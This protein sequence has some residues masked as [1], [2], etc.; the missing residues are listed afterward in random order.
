MAFP[1]TGYGFCIKAFC[2][3][4]RRLNPGRLPSI[5]TRG[6]Y[7]SPLWWP[8]ATGANTFRRRWTVS[9]DRPL[10][11]PRFLPS[12][13]RRA[14]ERWTSSRHRKTRILTQ[15]QAGL[16][17]A[18]NQGVEAALGDLIAFFDHD[19]LWH[20]RKLEAQACVLALFA[21]PATCI[22]NFRTVQDADAADPTKVVVPKHQTP[23]L[24]WTPSALIAHRDVFRTVG[25]GC[26]TDWFRRL[27]FSGIPCGV[28]TP[29]LLSKR[30][31]AQSL[32]RSVDRNRA[33]MFRVL[34]KHR[35]ETRGK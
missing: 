12:S 14:T 30:L 28:A 25:M 29:A 27:R 5:Q 7:R 32:S 34:E 33:A 2:G 26:D 4:G 17:G 1:T 10:R 19:D 11:L 15:S 16:A 24:G 3:A 9:G 6:R 23:R 31:H 20:P 35:A 13:D 21:R 22:T 8:F 18:R